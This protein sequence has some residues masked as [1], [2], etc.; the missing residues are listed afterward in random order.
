[1]FTSDR[2]KGAGMES[3]SIWRYLAVIRKRLWVIL[4]LFA[5]T[6][7]IILVRAWST[8]PVY[9]SSL[10][11]QVI[12]LEPEEVTLFT[13]TNAM[14]TSD[15]NDLTLFQFSNAARSASVAL[16]AI[17]AAG[18]NIPADELLDGLQITR[19][20]SGDKV[21]V[22]V[23]ARD[24][25]A[26]QKLVVAQVELAQAELQQTRSLPAVATGKFLETELA[27]SDRDLATA[28]DELLRFKL[29][30]NME[31]VER[32]TNAEQDAIRSLSGTREA[33]NVEAQR[34][35][36]MAVELER[37]SKEAETKA[38]EA[39]ARVKAAAAAKEE[40]SPDDVGAADTWRQL[41]QDLAR[42]A[43][44][45]RVDAAGQR[46]VGI[47]Y[48]GVISQHQTNL[49]SLITLGG[50]YQKLQDVVKERQDARDFLAGKVLEAR[51]KQAQVQ[52]VGYLQVVGE[53][54]TPTGQVSTRT[55]EI[56]I[57]GGGLSLVAGIVLVFLLEF[58]EQSARQ[59]PQRVR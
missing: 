53:P 13:R 17:A 50:Q 54:V 10:T 1:M 47:G 27:S 8:P 6:M 26:A 19:D 33:A 32:E 9:Q 20:P 36:A 39:E 22:S 57:I 14:S 5:A 24:P 43:S 25:Q 51:L 11:L 58:L 23:T 30:N 4:L 41:A 46:Q 48:A 35:I 28:K 45:R 2:F 16:R 7:V 12:P 15:L 40:V 34:L 44:S 37:Q 52:N 42:N 49:A 38:Q 59:K 3:S 21:T 29:A 55:L 18:V 56:A 31:S